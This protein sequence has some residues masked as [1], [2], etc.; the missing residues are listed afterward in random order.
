[1]AFTNSHRPAPPQAPGSGTPACR[2][3][4]FS[5]A[6]HQLEKLEF[7]LAVAV[8]RGDRARI[9]ELRERIAELGG[10]REEPGT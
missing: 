10:N 6:G 2:S 7:A 8:T 4:G 5:E 9:D 3:R 1:M